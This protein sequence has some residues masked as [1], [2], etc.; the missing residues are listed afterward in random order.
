MRDLVEELFDVKKKW[1]SI[2]LQLK[3]PDAKLDEIEHTC[4][5][6]LARAL[7][8]VLQEW[9]NQIGPRPTWAGVVK[10]LRTRTVNE[11]DLAANLEDRFASTARQ[12][13]SQQLEQIDVASVTSR[14][15]ALAARTS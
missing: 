2:G 9:R 12:A 1:Y 13:T 4:K 15:T 7:R 14:S 6:D 11:Q 10:A 8:L 5:D 3:V